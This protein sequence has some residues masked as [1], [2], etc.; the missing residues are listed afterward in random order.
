MHPDGRV[1]HRYKRRWVVERF[2]A[3]IQNYR[4]VAIRW[5]Y[6]IENYTGFVQLACML[7][8]LRLF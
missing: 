4:R 3:W 6:K 7:I 2:N 8:L 1:L 5:E